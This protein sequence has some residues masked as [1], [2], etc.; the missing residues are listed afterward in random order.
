MVVVGGC[1]PLCT[2]PRPVK[3]DAQRGWT[4]ECLVLCSEGI[5]DPWRIYRDVVPIC[6]QGLV[7]PRSLTR[8]F[9]QVCAEARLVCRFRAPFASTRGETTLSPKCWSDKK[10]REA[11]E[12]LEFLRWLCR[13]LASTCDLKQANARLLSEQSAATPSE[14]KGKKSA[15]LAVHS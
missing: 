15:L 1:S 14:P 3:K 9:T 8:S 13:W 12:F 6:A 4:L 10:E 2:D 11:A 7:F 5:G